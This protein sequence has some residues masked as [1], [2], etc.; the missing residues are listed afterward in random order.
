VGARG[1][2]TA[3]QRLRG[4]T[5]FELHLADRVQGEVFLMRRYEPALVAFL[6]DRLPP[7]GL[8]LDVG[9]HVGLVSIQVAVRRSDV[10]VRAFEPSS[11]NAA[12]LRRNLELNPGARVELVRAAVGG[13][14]GE[15]ELSTAAGGADLAGSRIVA[16]AAARP[17]TSTER[18]PVT[19]LDAYAA[20]HG[21]ERVHALKLDVEG[22][23]LAALEGAADLLA[24]R[25]IDCLV[26]ELNDV[27][28][29]ERGLGR[30]ALVD[31]LAAY[32]Y[33]PVEI[34]P[35][36]AQRLR[37]SR[38]AGQVADVAFVAEARK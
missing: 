27:Y 33:K 22:S 13:S 23:E 24:A 25:R 10:D 30:D 8:F 29:A 17:G 37:R 20:E 18:V 5:R 26:C 4:G 3:L 2:E 14:E 28:L 36:G 15:A 35:V 34:P 16:G 11:T 9:A 7:G 6:A 21:L 38:R 31:R 1:A 32:G 12:R 19:T